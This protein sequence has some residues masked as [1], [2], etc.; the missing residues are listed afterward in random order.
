MQQSEAAAELARGKCY[1]SLIQ[2]AIKLKVEYILHDSLA[3]L[4][5]AWSAMG[6]GVHLMHL[7][8]NPQDD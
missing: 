7:H 3:N 5:S 2:L 8:P 1:V 4:T 6:R